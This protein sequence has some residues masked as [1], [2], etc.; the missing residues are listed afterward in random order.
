MPRNIVSLL[1][2]WNS[3]LYVVVRWSNSYSNLLKVGSGVRQGSSLSPPLFNVFMNKVIINLKKP[4]LGFIL[5]KHGLDAFF[6]LM[7]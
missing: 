2:G 5:T 6:T 7:L 1:V 4:E 3:K